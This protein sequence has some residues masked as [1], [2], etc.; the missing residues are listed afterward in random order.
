VPNDDVGAKRYEIV[1]GVKVEAKAP[2]RLQN[3]VMY[4]ELRFVTAD[5]LTIPRGGRLRR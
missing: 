4:S 3:D 1:S 5:G 2:Q